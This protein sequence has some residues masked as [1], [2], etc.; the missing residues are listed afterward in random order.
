MNGEGPGLAQFRLGGTGTVWLPP[1]LAWQ[2]PLAPWSVY[3][4]DRLSGTILL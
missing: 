4:W 3:S 1:L 2:L